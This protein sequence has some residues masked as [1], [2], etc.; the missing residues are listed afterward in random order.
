MTTNRPRQ[1]D[2]KYTPVN[3]TK[4]E[5]FEAYRGLPLDKRTLESLKGALNEQ[6]RQVGHSLLG[7]RA[8]RGGW[9]AMLIEIEFTPTC[10]SRPYGEG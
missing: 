5:A 3:V 9:D 1:R 2:G 4:E 8:K 6:G 10:S 7:G